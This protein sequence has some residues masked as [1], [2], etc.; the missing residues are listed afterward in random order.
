MKIFPKPNKVACGF[1]T[2]TFPYTQCYTVSY[3]N[4]QKM[5]QRIITRAVLFFAFIYESFNVKN[6]KNKK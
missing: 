2:E 4:Y 5:I 6:K 1:G 3:S